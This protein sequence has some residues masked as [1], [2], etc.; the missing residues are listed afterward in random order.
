MA[1]KK[2]PKK[3]DAKKQDAK[4]KAAKEKKPKEDFGISVGDVFSS[5]IKGFFSNVPILMAAGL[6]VF[7]VFGLAS[8][9]WRS[10][11]SQLQERVDADL[12]STLSVIEQLQWVALLM[13]AAYPAGI[14]AAPWFRYA[15][16]VADGKKIDIKAP[17]IDGKKWINHAFAT[18]WFWAGVTLGFRYSFLI[19]GLPSLVVLLLYPFYGYIIAGGQEINGL[20]ALGVSVRLSQGRRIGLFAIAG[21]FFMFNLFGVVGL[22]VGLDVETG[23]PSLLGIVLGVLGVTAT[24]SATLVS[25]ATIYRVLEEKL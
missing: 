6:P 2:Q 11:N 14:V 9:P 3:Q 24:A 20:K 22:G 1:K 16:D 25:G 8:I 10:F 5:G 13:V 21:M 18:F 7:I 12:T 15:L 4:K 19:P 23:T 17:L